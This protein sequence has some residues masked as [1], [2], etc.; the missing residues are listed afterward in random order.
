[1]IFQKRHSKKTGLVFLGTT[2]N[3]LKTY[4]IKALRN[5]FGKIS[6][7]S[8]GV[9]ATAIKWIA[10]AINTGRVW[11]FIGAGRVW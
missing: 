11:A 4:F 8:R 10:V 2:A 1:L 5:V 9:I 6:D 7:I 3:N